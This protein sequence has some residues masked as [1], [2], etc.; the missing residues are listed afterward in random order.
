MANVYDVPATQLIELAALEL[1]KMDVFT[2]P[3][4]VPYIKTGVH[5]ERV[6]QQDEWWYTRCASILRRIYIDGPIGIER[7]RSYYGG[8]ESRPDR[9]HHFKKGSGSIVRKAI[10]Q[11]E[12]AKFLIKSKKG[13]SITPKGRSF[14]DKIATQIK[15]QAPVS[16]SA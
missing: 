12:K 6:P 11:L 8:R 7:L 5:R 15:P 1:K 2:P 13:R 16:K 3:V 10:Q 14:L 4:W 9:P